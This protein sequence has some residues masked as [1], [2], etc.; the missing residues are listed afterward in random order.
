[1][2]AQYLRREFYRRP[3]I[4]GHRARRN[5]SQLL[6]MKVLTVQSL[7]GFISI[8]RYN[9]QSG[10]SPLTNKSS[11]FL[12]WGNTNGSTWKLES[13]RAADI[14][15]WGI[16]A[17]WTCHSQLHSQCSA[18]GQIVSCDY[19]SRLRCNHKLNIRDCALQERVYPSDWA[20]RVRSPPIVL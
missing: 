16:Q 20:T 6:T 4:A 12:S 9:T 10:V 2:T 17:H 1:M 15:R 18:N 3:R 7:R 19:H 11:C 5:S 8:D 14:P 13:R